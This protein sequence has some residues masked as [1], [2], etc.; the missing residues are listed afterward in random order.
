MSG[1]IFPHP[2][3]NIGY[4][5]PNPHSRTYVNSDKGF[6]MDCSVVNIINPNNTDSS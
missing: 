2:V 3:T 6:Y 5:H 1:L 4:R